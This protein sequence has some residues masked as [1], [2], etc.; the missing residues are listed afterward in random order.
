M[1]ENELI[2][3]SMLIYFLFQQC[4]NKNKAT[5]NSTEITSQTD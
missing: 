3:L 1:D 5:T 4:Y 2:V